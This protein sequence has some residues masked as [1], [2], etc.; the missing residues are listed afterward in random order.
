MEVGIKV[1]HTDDFFSCLSLEEPEGIVYFISDVL[2]H[3][4]GM[5][6]M[7]CKTT[8]MYI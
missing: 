6:S 7:I 1:I 8:H 5:Y 3:E 4:A 2:L